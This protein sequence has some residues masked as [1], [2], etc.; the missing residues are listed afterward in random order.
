MYRFNIDGFSFQNKVHP[1]GI[2]LFI[3]STAFSCKTSS[4]SI[5]INCFD[6]VFLFLLSY[7]KKLRNTFIPP[8]GRYYSDRRREGFND[9]IIV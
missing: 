7:E 8:F 4:P 1:W 6:L 3:L 9:H 2:F 5:Q